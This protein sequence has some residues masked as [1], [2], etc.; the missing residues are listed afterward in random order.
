MNRGETA[1]RL[2]N[3]KPPA[4]ITMIRGCRNSKET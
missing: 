4:R 2:I 1:A 3:L